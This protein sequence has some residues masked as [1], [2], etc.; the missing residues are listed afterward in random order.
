M[1]GASSALTLEDLNKTQASSSLASPVVITQS[2]A[3]LDRKLYDVVMKLQAVRPADG[4]ETYQ[5]ISKLREQIHKG[6]VLDNLFEMAN[7]LINNAEKAVRNAQIAAVGSNKSTGQQVQYRY[8]VKPLSALGRSEKQNIDTLVIGDIHGQFDTFWSLLY[9]AGFIDKKSNWIAG[10][11]KL[12]QV[13]DVLDRGSEQEAFKAWNLLENLQIHAPQ[14]GGEVIRLLGNHELLYLTK[15]YQRNPAIAEKNGLYVHNGERWRGVIARAANEGKIIAAYP[16][17]GGIVVHGGV[18]PII[19][20]MSNGSHQLPEILAKEFNAKLV[21]AINKDMYKDVIFD[22]STG[23]FWARAKELV[24]FGDDLVSQIV[25]HD[26]YKNQSGN[27]A[28]S[29]GSRIIRVDAGMYLGYGGGKDALVISKERV[30]SPLT[31]NDRIAIGNSVQGATIGAGSGVGGISS[32]VAMSNIYRET[33]LRKSTIG[34]NG[35]GSGGIGNGGFGPG[36]GGGIASPVSKK[37]ELTSNIFNSMMMPLQPSNTKDT[38]NNKD[39]KEIPALPP[40]PT[41]NGS[42]PNTTGTSPGSSPNG[43]NPN[44]MSPGTLP[45]Y[46]SL[47]FPFSSAMGGISNKVLILMLLNSSLAKGA[48]GIVGPARLC[49]SLLQGLK[50]SAQ[51]NISKYQ[52]ALL[53]VPIYAGVAGIVVASQKVGAR[54]GTEGA[55]SANAV[56][57]SK[58]GIGAGSSIGVT[59]GSQSAASR[60]QREGNTTKYP[61]LSLNLLLQPAVS[62]SPLGNA[63]STPES[64]NKLG[65]VLSR[66]RYVS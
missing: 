56:I 44:I 35:F 6:I 33:E 42:S 51:N 31:T 5:E 50:I 59:G 54:I 53:L 45:M 25:G 27:N 2:L 36:L 11:R 30:A 32:A 29:I 61:S 66:L 34:G 4:Y 17:A 46:V 60:K 8:G 9:S 43:V 10:D 23:I 62:G 18:H 57:G 37:V 40:S 38:R 12:F 65:S 39:N 48:G 41:N 20:K 13:G 22:N 52:V 64:T 16:Y 24:N 58:Q 49:A 26:V 14:H 1:A 7:M 55:Q 21:E 15:D 63:L 19:S 47:I 3:D 28:I